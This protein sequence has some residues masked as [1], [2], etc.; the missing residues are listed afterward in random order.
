M[1]WKVF[2]LRNSYAHN[3]PRHNKCGQCSVA[4]SPWFHWIFTQMIPRGFMSWCHPWC[5]FMRVLLSEAK[6]SSTHLPTMVPRFWLL[7][8]SGLLLVLKYYLS[9]TAHAHWAPPHLL[10][11][12]R[13]LRCSARRM[14]ENRRML[15][16]TREM[17]G[18]TC[19]KITRN[20]RRHT[21]DI[22]CR[23]IVCRV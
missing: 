12:R 17:Q 3:S 10:M 20:L 19:T 22:V 4:S 16:M 21:V 6:V 11:V 1:R 23:Y 15:R 13:R 9:H 14:A 5:G 8:F 7:L 2:L 18:N